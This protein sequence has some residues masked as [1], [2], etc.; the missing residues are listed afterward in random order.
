MRDPSTRNFEPPAQVM[1]L[2]ALREHDCVD[3]LALEEVQ[4]PINTSHLKPLKTRPI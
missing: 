4:T 1:A 2:H 3:A